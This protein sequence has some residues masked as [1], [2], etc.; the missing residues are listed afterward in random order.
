M[1]QFDVSIVHR[2]SDDLENVAKSM[3]ERVNTPVELQDEITQ[4]NSIL[5]SL[6][7]L[8]TSAKNAG[9]NPLVEE[10]RIK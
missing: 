1:N 5:G 8:I 7:S 6:Q 3:K 10:N 2:L 9:T 4:I